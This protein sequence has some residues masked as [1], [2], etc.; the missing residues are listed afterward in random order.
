MVIVSRRHRALALVGLFFTSFFLSFLPMLAFPQPGF[1]QS[2]EALA[3]CSF[4]PETSPETRRHNA[5][6]GVA[7][8]R[9][10]SCEQAAQVYFR[11]RLA[12]ESFE[13]FLARAMDIFRS[14]ALARDWFLS[15]PTDRNGQP[16][17]TGRINDPGTFAAYPI[18]APSNPFRSSSFS[19]LPVG[20]TTNGWPIY[21]H[22]FVRREWDNVLRGGSI[23]VA[24]T[25]QVNPYTGQGLVTKIVDFRTLSSDPVT[26]FFVAARG[27]AVPNANATQNRVSEALP[28]DIES[29]DGWLDRLSNE[30]ILQLVEIGSLFIPQVRLAR[31]ATRV[32]SAVLQRFPRIR[33][34]LRD[35]SGDLF[36]R[37]P[38][39]SG[40]SF[41]ADQTQLQA[42]F[43]HARAFGIEGNWNRANAQL[44]EQALRYHVYNNPNTVRIVGTYRG[45]AAIHYVDPTTRLHVMTYPNGSLWSARNLRPEQFQNVMQRGSL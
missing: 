36:A 23:D 41:R 33:E 27:D 9:W 40:W 26:A 3:L 29:D 21:R 38:A 30:D 13:R 18:S 17:G 1:S 5:D 45:E 28:D 14:A 10:I 37:I 35:Q 6:V 4:V 31:I 8:S 7:R 22:T 19:I 2:R 12:G 15:N 42:K 16:L 11:E 43:K 44:F 32:G 25:D 34:F 39:R 20:R 24:F